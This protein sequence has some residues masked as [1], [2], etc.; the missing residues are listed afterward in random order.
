M[1]INVINDDQSVPKDTVLP[2]M[3]LFSIICN[4]YLGLWMSKLRDSYK[5]LV[6]DRRGIP[7]SDLSN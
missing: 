6:S 2:L 3:L 4:V 7:I 1:A 5:Q